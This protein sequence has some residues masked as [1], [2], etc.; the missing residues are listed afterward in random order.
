MVVMGTPGT[1]KTTVSRLLASRM[2]ALHMDLGELV[3]AEKLFSSVDRKRKSLVADIPRVAR[4]V[5]EIIGKSRRS[6]IIDGH[7]VADIVPFD[8]VH[9]AFVLR[10]DPD[11]LKKRLESEGVKGE[12]NLE[13]VAA[14]ILDVCLWDAVNAYGVKKI[15]EID[16]SNKKPEDVVKEILAVLRGKIKATIGKV[17]WLKKLE[18]EG[19]VRE[20]LG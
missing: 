10:C 14:E 11:K 6:I 12:K 20:F 19:R 13:N 15:C 2:K 9:L 3:A 1:G 4:R 18:E 8:S 7:Y 17:D 16:T 5:R